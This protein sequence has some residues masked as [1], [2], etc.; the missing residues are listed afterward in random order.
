VGFCP[1][2]LRQ[3]LALTGFS[4]LVCRTERWQIPLSTFSRAERILVKLASS[5]GQRLG[6]GMGITCWAQAT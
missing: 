3:A 5:A 1:R 4:V 2:S 6:M